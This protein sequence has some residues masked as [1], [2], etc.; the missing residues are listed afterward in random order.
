MESWSEHWHHP[1]AATRAAVRF[2]NRDGNYKARKLRVAMVSC[3]GVYHHSVESGA[4]VKETDSLTCPTNVSG[5]TSP[6]DKTRK[7]ANPL[8]VTPA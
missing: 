3:A 6:E 1:L 8:F 7:T 4:V 2:C 5:I